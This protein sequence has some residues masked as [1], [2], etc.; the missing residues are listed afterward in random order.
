MKVTK[1]TLQKLEE[2]L[3]EIGVAA[4]DENGNYRL[5]KDVLNDVCKKAAENRD[6]C[7]DYGA[8]CS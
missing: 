6:I 3:A 1:E 7:F 2:T 5:L 8:F 4:K